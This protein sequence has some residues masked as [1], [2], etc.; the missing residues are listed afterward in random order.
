[1]PKA[2]IPSVNLDAI[3]QELRDLPRWACW[4]ETPSTG[5]KKAGKPPIQAN[6][7]FTGRHVYAKAND[8]KS[9]A[10]FDMALRYWR[11][12]LR[13]KGLASGLSIAL[14]GDGIVGM[15]MDRC[16]NVKTKAIDGW[17]LEIIKRFRTYTGV[18]PSGTGIRIFLRGKLPA[19]GRHKGQI[20]VYGAGKF[21]SVTGRKLT[22]HG[23]GDGIEERSAELLTWYR[24]VFGAGPTSTK[25]K[26]DTGNLVIHD[27][28]DLDQGRLDRLFRM[29]PQ[30][31]DL[32]QGH[33]DKPSQPKPVGFRVTGK[34]LEFGEAPQ[35][36]KKETQKGN[37]EEW[38]KENM[39][40]GKWYPAADLLANAEDDGFSETALRRARSDLGIVKPQHVRRTPTGWEW[41]LPGQCLGKTPGKT[42][43]T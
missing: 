10:S 34:G 1:M 40:P 15:D 12:Q 28:P 22:G 16:R 42:V 14:N 13:G 35:R 23:A 24:E 25:E 18:S 20:E 31:R 37:A 43:P 36:P 26:G 4:K 30:A 39:E 6:V 2:V 29:K 9:W 41:R 11:D 5:D 7:K 27:L 8:P 38:L 32:L 3:P 17:A 19:G 21:L 33:H